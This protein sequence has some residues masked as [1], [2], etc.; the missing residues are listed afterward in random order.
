MGENVNRAEYCGTYDVVRADFEKSVAQFGLPFEAAES[1][2]RAHRL[3]LVREVNAVGQGADESHDEVRQSLRC[4]NG[5]ASLWRG[6]ISPACLAC[7]KGERTATFFVS[8]K[9]TKH[10]YFCFNP[11][12]ED[13]EFFRT[14]T[15]DIAEELRQA[16]AQGAQFDCL[17]IT[18]GEPCLHKPEV[19]EFLRCAKELY[20]GVHVRIYTSGD[21]L[22][23]AFLNDLAE[24][25]LDELRFSVKPQDT[26]GDQ[27]ELFGRMAAA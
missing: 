26:D 21:L 11:N 6:W 8:L 2:P 19:L 20:P 15:R 27:E 22:D 13:Y 25:G 9:C 16:H 3:E 12:Q 10:C 23:D 5:D 14:H 24:A 4:E 17:A 1:C 7:R 18:G